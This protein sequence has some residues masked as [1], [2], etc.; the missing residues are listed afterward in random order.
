MLGPAER[1]HKCLD[2]ATY[3]PPRRPTPPPP[4]PLLDELQVRARVRSEPGR[5]TGGCE[6]YTIIP[7]NMMAAAR[8]KSQLVVAFSTSR[9]KMKA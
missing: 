3:P 9:A 1:G 7:Q 2:A 5:V 8:K 6:W 4:P